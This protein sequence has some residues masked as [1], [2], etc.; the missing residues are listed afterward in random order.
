MIT[1]SNT[2]QVLECAK[3]ERMSIKEIMDEIN[4]Q[5]YNLI[6]REKNTI[7]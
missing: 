5:N 2:A 6:F 1:F 4:N 7:E 3:L